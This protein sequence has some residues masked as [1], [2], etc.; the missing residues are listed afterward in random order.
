MPRTA[1]VFLVRLL[2]D[3]PRSAMRW[4]AIHLAGR[5]PR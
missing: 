5:G 4:L 1:L 2:I 3:G